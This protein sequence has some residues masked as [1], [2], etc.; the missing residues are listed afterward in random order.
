[1]IKLLKKFWN[2]LFKK[3]DRN[4]Y[5]FK[6]ILDNPSKK[7]LRKNT[8]YIVGNEEYQKWA[9]LLCPCGCEEAIMLSLNQNMNP[10]WFFI[11]NANGV[12]TIYPSINKLDNCMSHFWIKEGKL[13]WSNSVVS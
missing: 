3:K 4:L 7:N 10:S 13:I 9:Y 2:Y 11:S 1:M 5:S 6:F 8:I 12:P